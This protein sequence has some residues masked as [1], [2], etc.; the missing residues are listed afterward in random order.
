[1]QLIMQYRLHKVF[2]FKMLKICLTM[3][4]IS[5]FCSP[6]PIESLLA[7]RS[8]YRKHSQ[9]NLNIPRIRGG[10]W[11]PVST[12]MIASSS[13]SMDALLSVVVLSETVIWLKIWTGLASNGI[14]PPNLTRKIIHTGSAPLFLI[15]WPLYSTS[16]YAK[17][18]A[19]TIPLLQIIRFCSPQYLLENFYNIGLKG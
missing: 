18:L 9:V 17:F 2:S 5:I 6:T 3:L 16:P 13:L 19:S 8:C 10:A 11:S 12:N 1:M 15:H 14:L 4:S 7:Q